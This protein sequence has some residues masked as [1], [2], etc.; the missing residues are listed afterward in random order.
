MKT[1]PP[2]KIEEILTKMDKNTDPIEIKDLVERFLCDISKKVSDLVEQ[3][4]FEEAIKEFTNI[5]I[6]CNKAI[7]TVKGFDNPS[8]LS[9][10]L[11]GLQD[12]ASYWKESFE[13][14]RIEALR[15]QVKEKWNEGLA[16]F[17]NG[18]Y[19]NALKSFDEAL[20][21]DLQ[22][23]KHSILVDKGN[24]FYSQGDLKQAMNLYKQ[25]LELNPKSIAA[26]GNIGLVLLKLADYENAIKW[27]D[28]VLRINEKDVD[29]WI[30]KSFSFIN[31]KKYDEAIKCI[32]IAI[33][34][35]P[36]N[37]LA[38]YYKGLALSGRGFA[39]EEQ[40][41]DQLAKNNFMN[42]LEC[43]LHAISISPNDVY[44][45]RDIG[46]IY[47][48]LKEYDKAM[49]YFKRLEELDPNNSDAANLKGVVAEEIGKYDE[50]LKYYSRATD[51]NPDEVLPRINMAET[52]LLMGQYSQSEEMARKVLAMTTDFIYIYVIRHL[53]VC[54][55]YLRNVEEANEEAIDLLNYYKSF[56]SD[57]VINWDFSCLTKFLNKSDL[58][59]NKKNSLDLLIDAIKKKRDANQVMSELENSIRQESR[60]NKA[61]DLFRIRKKKP[62]VDVN[63]S[64]VSTVFLTDKPGW[65]DWEIHFDEPS[66]R[67]AEI[68]S[69]TYILHP[70]F[71]NPE[72]KVDNKQD[73][74]MLKGRGWGSFQVKIIINLEN[75]ESV[76]KYHWLDISV[77]SVMKQM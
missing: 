57:Y 28:E 77:A 66:Q 26:L 50:A 46:M 25:A 40:D 75:G 15:T 58:S 14:L 49:E 17:S 33:I 71:P 72:R 68:K 31:L 52:L 47:R 59:V 24:V 16:S 67:L 22:D 4:K 41:Q 39:F 56:P 29:A 6:A 44:C 20:N 11:A 69:V 45:I 73:Q 42:A 21:S 34:I 10:L 43:Y 62:N 54:S 13:K 76:T 12:A 64:T 60:L 23:N 53:I 51:L 8:N 48:H 30:N 63:F 19:D 3:R 38:L 74:F 5:E 32:D 61:V 36:Q 18:Q 27:F 1:K 65:Y 55:L 70:T 9:S 7:E 2:I 35:K 37:S